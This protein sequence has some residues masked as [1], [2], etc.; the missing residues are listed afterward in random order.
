MVS[1]SVTSIYSSQLSRASGDEGH[2]SAALRA[3]DH[4]KIAVVPNYT[5][6]YKKKSAAS[7][8]SGMEFGIPSVPRLGVSRWKN[9]STSTNRKQGWAEADHGI[10]GSSDIADTAGSSE[11]LPDSTRE[12]GIVS[13]ADTGTDSPIEWSP[14]LYFGFA[15]FSKRTFLSPTIHVDGHSQK[16]LSAHRATRVRSASVL[17]GTPVSA[18]P[19]FANQTPH[20]GLLSEPGL[21]SLITDP[22]AHP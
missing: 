8:S 17:G 15:D 20:T 7:P 6:T 4:L 21:H 16:R 12:T 10:A 3:S 2:G 11:T 14:G 19:S 5:D 22:L 18:I 13:P 9:Q 1:G